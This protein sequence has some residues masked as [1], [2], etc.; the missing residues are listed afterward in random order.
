MDGLD[1]DLGLVVDL[2]ADEMGVGDLGV[3]VVEPDGLAVDLQVQGLRVKRRDGVGLSHLDHLVVF[4]LMM[5][6]DT[7]LCY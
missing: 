2:M 3:V 5:L 6:K 4:G 1:L 7:N